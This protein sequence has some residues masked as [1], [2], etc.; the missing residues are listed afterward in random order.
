MVHPDRVLDEAGL[1]KLPPVEPVYGLTEGL[2]Q[3]VVAKAAT[4]ALDRLPGLPE[5]HGRQASRAGLRAF[6][7][8]PARSST[9]RN[10]RRISRPR[11]IPR[12]AARL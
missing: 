12:A 9:T 8:R 2:F 6:G 3:R 5:W 10:S 4:A 7:A 1:A 11:Q